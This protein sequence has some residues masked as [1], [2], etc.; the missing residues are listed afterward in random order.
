VGVRLGAP[1]RQLRRYRA[2]TREDSRDRRRDIL[3]MA[4]WLKFPSHL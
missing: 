2:G 1:R 4:D 3:K